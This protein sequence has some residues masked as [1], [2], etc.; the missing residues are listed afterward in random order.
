VTRVSSPPEREQVALE[1]LVGQAEALDDAAQ[2]AAVG[3]ASR[4][5]E[6]A[7]QLLVRLHRV[8]QLG[9]VLGEAGEA[10]LGG[11]QR[12]LELDG[13]AERLQE[14]VAHGAVA[15]EFRRLFVQPHAAPAGARDGP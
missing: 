15:L 10:L 12:F 3:V 2:A 7:L 8:A 11:A 13:L 5:L 1:H 9:T 14:V 6:A 4:S